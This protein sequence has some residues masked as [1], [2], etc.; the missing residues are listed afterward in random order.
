M[1]SIASF[2]EIQGADD[3]EYAEV[4]AYGKIVRI[5][6]LNSIDMIE[7][8]DAKAGDE[9]KMEAGLRLIVKS[10]VDAD[11]NRVPEDKFE[12]LLSSFRTKNARSNSKVISAALKLNGFESKPKNPSG[13]GASAGSDTASPLQL[14]T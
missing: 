1:S 6:S 5:G 11:G 2:D 8:A 3:T 4:E 12:A 13:E 14:E 9:G 7:W 10:L